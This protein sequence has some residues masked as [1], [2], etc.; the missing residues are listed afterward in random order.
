MA[1][2][3]YTWRKQPNE[4]GLAGVCQSP[5]G[6]LLNYGGQAVATVRPRCDTHRRIIGWYW[7]GDG[8]NTAYRFAATVDEAKAECMAHFKAKASAPGAG[9]GEAEA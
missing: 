8:V 5:R 2:P 7:C 4:K 6:F 3:R 9:G 1:K